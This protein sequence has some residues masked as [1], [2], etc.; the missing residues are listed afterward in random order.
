MVGHARQGNDI[1]GLLERLKTEVDADF[2]VFYDIAVTDSLACYADPVIVSDDETLRSAWTSWVRG[3]VQLGSI[4]ANDQHNRR[5]FKDGRHGTHLAPQSRNHFRL[6]D[7]DVNRHTIAHVPF[8]QELYD[9][10]NADQLRAVIFDGRRFLGWVGLLRCERP[11]SDNERIRVNRAIAEVR[12]VL[13]TTKS[14]RGGLDAWSGTHVLMSSDGACLLA[15]PCLRPW[16]SAERK[17]ALKRA[18]REFVRDGTMTFQV[19]GLL[20]RCS[21]MQGDHGDGVLACIERGRSLVLAPL[22]LLTDAEYRV[23]SLLQ[24][25]ATVPEISRELDRSP[26]TVKRQ[27][28]SIYD[29][30]NVASRAEFVT[31]LQS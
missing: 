31:L 27:V 9:R 29:R 1:R 26:N 8:F 15:S 3:P 7:Q 28:K 4:L 16:L 6:L 25:G 11:F 24:L 19:D 10:F 21:W 18:A 17:E 20:L 22:A 13:L 2:A 30:L 23:A 14:L 5:Y 12:T